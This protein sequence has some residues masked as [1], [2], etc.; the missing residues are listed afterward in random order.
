MK[1]IL[2]LLAG[3]AMV[4]ALSFQSYAEDAFRGN[5]LFSDDMI[6]KE[7]A[8]KILDKAPKKLEIKKDNTL[9]ERRKE[10][11]LQVKAEDPKDA[12]PFGL[13]WGASRKETT[14]LGVILKPITKKGFINA[15]IATQLTKPLKDFKD[16]E[17]VFGEENEL[18]RVIAYSEYNDD[19][20]KASKGLGLYNQYY[21]LLSNKYCKGNQ[22]YTPKVTIK[23]KIV[24]IGMGKTKTETEE[25][26]EPIGGEGFLDFL[27]NRDAHLFSTFK[28]DDV[29][30]FLSLQVND[31]GQSYILI[32]YKNLNLIKKRDQK[33]LEAL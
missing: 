3:S 5:L 7:S 9:V 4:F 23:E 33:T 11:Q 12:A 10:K 25:I 19:N 13:L 26:N 24:D 17:V 20:T 30:V 29:E 16:V 14:Q 22:Q 15:F 6:A 27:Q 1:K 21:K 31:K 28:G 32:D 18:W 8:G 2:A